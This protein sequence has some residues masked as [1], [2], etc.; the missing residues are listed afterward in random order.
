MYF[1][2]WWLQN[3]LYPI[4]KLRHCYY[5]VFL[6][7]GLIFSFLFGQELCY[8]SGSYCTVYIYIYIYIYISQRHSKKKKYIY[9][10]LLW[11]CDPTRAMAS[12]FLMFLDHTQRRTTVGRTTL[13]E[14]SVRRR[15]LYLTTQHSQQ[16][17]IHAP[18]GI[19]THNLSGRAAADL[20]LRPR[21]HW[22]RHCTVY[23]SVLNQYCVSS[24]DSELGGMSSAW[25][26][27][28]SLSK[29][30]GS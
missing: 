30:G 2:K 11:R 26:T 18:G 17:K 19:R 8:N 1:N 4:L 20:R 21:G 6:W 25:I 15:D 3:S 9:I 16:T 23:I 22:D 7:F 10:F 28:P 5:S 12:S 13:D 24:G 27:S 14:W 29:I